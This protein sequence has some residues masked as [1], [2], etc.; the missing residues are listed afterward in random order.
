M[1]AE[2]RFVRSRI[3]RHRG[4]LDKAVEPAE[5]AL[6]LFSK[7]ENKPRVALLR[8]SLGELY[9]GMGRLDEAKKSYQ[10]AR[11]AFDELRDDF[12]IGWCELGLASTAKHAG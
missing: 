7:H 1:L 5:E 10:A 9:R 3:R 6:A 11:K 4:E 2:S 12:Q 8:R